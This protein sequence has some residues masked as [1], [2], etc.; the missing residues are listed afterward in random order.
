[1]NRNS[2]QVNNAFI[3]IGTHLKT[4]RLLYK[5]KAT[6]VAERAGISLKVL[7]K[8]ENGDS[9]VTTSALLEVV[10]SLGLLETLTDSIDPLASDLGK[11]RINDKLPKRIK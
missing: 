1:M 6:Q 3:E 2:I 7:R 9:T 8:I 10:R 4:W 11:A 5:L